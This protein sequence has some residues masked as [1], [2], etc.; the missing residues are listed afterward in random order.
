M[1]AMTV[2]ASCMAIYIV[3]RFYIVLI[4]PVSHFSW[5]LGVYS[6]TI[7]SAMRAA[8]QLPGRWY[9]TPFQ[10]LPA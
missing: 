10:F 6:T 3:R 2:S 8:N 1:E 9:L 4:G 7:G 5:D